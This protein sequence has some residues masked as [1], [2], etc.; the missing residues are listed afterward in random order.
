MKWVKRWGYEMAATTARPGIYRMKAGGFFVRARV[1]DR[2]TGKRKA[3]TAALHGV[4]TPTDAQ[5]E[6]DKLV[7]VAR[8]ELRGEIRS[9]PLW[10]AFAASLLE[11]RVARGDIESAATVERWAG[12]L[13]D[14]LI[15]AF[16]HMRATEVAFSHVDRWLT[17]TVVLVWMRKG[18]LIQRRRR[19]GTPIGKPRLVKLKPTTVNGILRMLATISE[20]IRLKFS[21]PKS[22]FEGIAFLPEGRIYTRERPN[23]LPP[24]TLP[25]FL[26]IARRR[27]PQHYL[28]ILLGFVS[29]ARPGELRPIRRKGP[30]SD[31]DRTTGILLIRRSHARSQIVKDST[32]TK[33]DREIALPPTLI[34]EIDRHVEALPTPEAKASDLLFP[35]DDGRLRSRT[36]LTKPFETIMEELGLGTHVTPRAMRRTFN[37]LA[38]ELGLANAITRSISGHKTDEMQLHYSTARD[39]EQRAALGRVQAIAEDQT[40]EGDRDE[41][42]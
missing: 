32:K 27:Y 19:D 41:R 5:R 38:R 17:K 6:L 16:G 1:T 18:K 21:L 36:V 23:S 31:L 26:A 7:D 33:A 12:A 30:E 24:D 37:D 4:K 15:P 42:V 20:A 34:E 28:M 29:G 40:T 13:K 25:R 22:A 2:R 39:E 9:S 35:A 8:A 14:Y 11:E 3:I 10:S